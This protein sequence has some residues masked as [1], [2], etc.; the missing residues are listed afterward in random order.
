M[1]F[2]GGVTLKTSMV[3]LYGQ[4]SGYGVYKS[5]CWIRGLRHKIVSMNEAQIV[6]MGNSPRH[7]HLY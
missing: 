5:L 4:Q 3:Y 1:Y 7:F 2:E 6:C